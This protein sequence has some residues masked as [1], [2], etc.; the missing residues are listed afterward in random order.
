MGNERQ[1][2]L[3]YADADARWILGTSKEFSR[4]LDEK[5]SHARQDRRDCHRWISNKVEATNDLVDLAQNLVDVV[6]S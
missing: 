1:G 6:V 5:I 2:S 4:R 3:G